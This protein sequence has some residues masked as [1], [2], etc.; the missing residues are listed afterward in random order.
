MTN[1]FKGDDLV[2]IITV[3]RPSGTDSLVIVKCEV[4]VGKLLFVET[5]PVFPYRITIDRNKSKEL[6][7]QNEIYVRIYF[8]NGSTRR[9]CIGSLILSANAQVVR[10]E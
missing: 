10:D 3:H 8:N 1:I 7:Y 2:D 5:N 4:Q 6:D 9:T